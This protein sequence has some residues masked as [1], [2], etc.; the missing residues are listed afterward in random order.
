MMFCHLPDNR[1]RRTNHDYMGFLEFMPNELKAFM[2]LHN[3]VSCLGLEYEM[4]VLLQVVPFV[5]YL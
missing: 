1:T 2:V 5:L 3:V 4:D